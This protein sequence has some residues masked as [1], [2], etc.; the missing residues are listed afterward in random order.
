MRILFGCFCL[1]MPQHFSNK[2]KAVAPGHGHA[3][4]AMSQ[5]VDAHIIKARPCPNV[6]PNLPKPNKVAVAAGCRENEWISLNAGQGTQQVER[7]GAERNGFRVGFGL[8]Q[9]NLTT[10]EITPLPAQTQ[11][12]ALVRR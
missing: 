5:V 4:E 8:R 12:F 6:P 1:P 3:G 2:V 11:D 10:L 7:R 9:P